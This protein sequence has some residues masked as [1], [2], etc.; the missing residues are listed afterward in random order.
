MTAFSQSQSFPRVKWILAVAIFSCLFVPRI[1][2]NFFLNAYSLD[3]RIEDF[4]LAGLGIFTAVLAFKGEFR[5]TFPEVPSIENAFILL[6][7]AF[8]LSIFNGLYTRTIDKPLYSLFCLLKWVE[9]LLLFFITSRLAFSY[10]MRRFFIQIFFMLGLTLAIYG[11]LEYFFPHAKVMYPSYYRLFERFPFRGDANHIGGVFVLWVGFFTA[12]FLYSSNW[13]LR[14]GLLAA[15]IFVFFPFLWTYSRK[16]YFALGG[17]LGFALLI[18]SQKRPLF[19]LISCFALLALFV[20]TRVPERLSDLAQV[21]TSTNPLQSSW[22]GDLDVWHKIFWNF[23][24]F[25]VF[26]SG[27]G[28]RHRL[29]YESQYVMQLAETGILGFGVFLYFILCLIRQAWQ[30]LRN[31]RR[32]DEWVWAGWFL[33]FVGLMIHNLSCISLTVVKV[34]IPFW[35]LTATVFAHPLQRLEK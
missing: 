33:A 5:Q 23:E 22:T 26:G 12:Q 25:F 24:N 34:A 15:L 18:C 8:S 1:S 27:L 31:S 29:F 3:L 19:F 30:G 21:L 10:E 9:Y 20:P 6:F 16:S 35:Y 13:K 14:A 11:Y 4:L 7:I 28:S 17:S 2:V 32:E